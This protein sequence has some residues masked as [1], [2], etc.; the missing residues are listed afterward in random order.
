[1]E[2]HHHPHSHSYDNHQ[3]ANWKKYL[4]EFLMLFLAV[5]CGF[6]AEL[7]VEKSIDSHKEKEYINS[8]I[9]DLGKDTSNFNT[10]AKAFAENAKQFDFLIKEFNY[11]V[12]GNSTEWNGKF[13]KSVKVGFPDFFYTDRTIQQMKNSGGV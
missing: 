13:I 6:L 3:G 8:M 5:F 2:V 9:E 7:Q 1:M 10:V 11:G 12:K 4:W